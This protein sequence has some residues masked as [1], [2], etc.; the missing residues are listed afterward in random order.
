[1]LKGNI[2][3]NDNGKRYFLIACKGDVAI[4]RSMEDDFFNNGEYIVAVGFN[5][6]IGSWGGGSYWGSDFFGAAERF[7]QKVKEWEECKIV[8]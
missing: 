5:P 3:N 6:G 1:M 2:Y 8:G 7:K 4:L